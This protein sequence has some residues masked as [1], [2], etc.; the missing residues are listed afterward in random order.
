MSS[1]Q[2]LAA[3]CES[4]PCIAETTPTQYLVQEVTKIVVL[5]KAQVRLDSISA[6][7]W[8]SIYAPPL[9]EPSGEEHGFP[10]RTAADT[11]A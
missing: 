9:E 5:K 11:R 6:A 4:E 8:S 10:S 1:T 2:D 7:D 3:S